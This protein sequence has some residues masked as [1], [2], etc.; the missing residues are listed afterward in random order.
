MPDLCRRSQVWRDSTGYERDNMTKTE[1]TTA[2]LTLEGG[3]FRDLARVTVAAVT[4]NTR[5][6][7]TGVLVESDGKRVTFTATDSY[8]LARA[9]LEHSGAT[10]SAI[11]P[12]KLISE[13]SA[14]VK[15]ASS[16]GK[17]SSIGTGVTVDIAVTDETVTVTVSGP[18]GQHVT[19]SSVIW[20]TYPAVAQLIPTEPTATERIAFNPSFMA[21]AAKITPDCVVDKTAVIRLE[22]HDATRPATFS[23][24]CSTHAVEVLYL[25]M[26]VRVS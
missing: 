16:K 4:D 14:L 12:A 8:R 19:T 23:A 25:L 18:Q 15:K 22:L 21:D 2:T 1:T 9:S 7:L 11:I 24:T 20:G 17:R 6:I 26:P 5:P 13:T 10:F 3:P